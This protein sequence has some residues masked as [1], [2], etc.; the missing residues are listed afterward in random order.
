MVQVK[1][2]SSLIKTTLITWSQIDVIILYMFHI[3][4]IWCFARHVFP[5]FG[6]SSP[7]LSSFRSFLLSPSFLLPRSGPDGHIVVTP[8]PPICIVSVDCLKKISLTDFY[9]RQPPEL[10]PWTNSSKEKPPPTHLLLTK[11]SPINTPLSLLALFSFIHSYIN[12]V[13]G[14]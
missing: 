6:S 11:T 13:L 1:S 5:T 3:Y 14:Y 9:A 7:S 10:D 12:V 2:F 4:V 8:L